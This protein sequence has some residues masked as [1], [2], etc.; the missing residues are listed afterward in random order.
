MD[1]QEQDKQEQRQRQTVRSMFPYLGYVLVA[2][3]LIGYFVWLCA[4]MSGQTVSGGPSVAA[5]FGA[6]V[7]GVVLGGIGMFLGRSL[8]DH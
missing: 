7:G 5:I 1:K 2:A 3:V 6:A 8:R 4:E